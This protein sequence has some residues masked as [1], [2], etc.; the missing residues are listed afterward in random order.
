M[1]KKRGDQNSN[2]AASGVPLQEASV[3]SKKGKVQACHGFY[4]IKMRYLSSEKSIFEIN[5][6]TFNI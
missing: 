5:T 1:L 3:N 6:L 4:Q 2:M